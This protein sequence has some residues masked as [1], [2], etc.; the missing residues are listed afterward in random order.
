[1]SEKIKDE[2]DKIVS[3]MAE[4]DVCGQNHPVRGSCA[5]EDTVLYENK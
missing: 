2:L 5:R 1:V 3:A 4:T